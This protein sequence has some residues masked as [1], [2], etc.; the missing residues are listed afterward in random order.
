MKKYAFPIKNA[1]GTQVIMTVQSVKGSMWS[2]NHSNTAVGIVLVGNS[3][4]P[5]RLLP[6]VD[7]K[8]NF[9]KKK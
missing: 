6:A 8:H 9:K 4:G 5:S 7:S 1:I 2:S 3:L